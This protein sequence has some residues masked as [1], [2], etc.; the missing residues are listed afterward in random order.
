MSDSE[1]REKFPGFFLRKKQS[2][3]DRTMCIKKEKSVELFDNKLSKLS[4][5]KNKKNVEK[6]LVWKSYPRY[7]HKIIPF[8]WKTWI[9]K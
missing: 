8:R 2:R 3:N 9:K 4:T 7:P 5:P 1:I 6:P